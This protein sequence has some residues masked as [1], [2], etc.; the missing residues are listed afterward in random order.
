MDYVKYIY[1]FGE[2][3][4]TQKQAIIKLVE[5]KDKVKRLKRLAK[6]RKYLKYQL[7]VLETFLPNIIH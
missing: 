7:N 4:S 5:K 3:S 1:E 6:Q 2:L